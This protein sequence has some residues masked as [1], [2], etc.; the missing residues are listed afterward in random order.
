MLANSQRCL[1]MKLHFTVKSNVLDIIERHDKGMIS[2][3]E[4][5]GC[6]FD[7]NSKISFV[8]SSS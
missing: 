4:E 6:V 8:K 3:A 7:D 2:T 5:T 1:N